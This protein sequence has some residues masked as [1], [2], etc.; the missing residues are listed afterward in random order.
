MALDNN[1]MNTTVDFDGGSNTIINTSKSISNIDNAIPKTF[2]TAGMAVTRNSI[3][4][5][6]IEELDLSELLKEINSTN[7]STIDKG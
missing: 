2:N 7:A 4:N 6:V 3:D 5:L 1:I